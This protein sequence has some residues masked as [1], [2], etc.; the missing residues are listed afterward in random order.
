MLKLIIIKD[1]QQIFNNEVKDLEIQNFNSSR[2]GEIVD[3][4]FESCGIHYEMSLPLKE[5]Y[6]ITSENKEE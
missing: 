1:C 3:L 5:N 2:R 6:S 4:N